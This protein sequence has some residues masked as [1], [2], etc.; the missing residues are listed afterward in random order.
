MIA[1]GVKSVFS[2]DQVF[3]IELFSVGHQSVF[4]ANS[5]FFPLMSEFINRNG[6]AGRR[7]VGALVSARGPA[8]VEM[9]IGEHTTQAADSDVLP[10]TR[11]AKRYV[12][13]PFRF[14][15]SPSVW[16]PG[17]EASS[18]GM[19]RRDERRPRARFRQRYI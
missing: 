15:N 12:E 2:V 13:T 8:S 4:S 6:R 3:S 19:S 11:R 18:S 9:T 5:S 1:T 10:S 17:G 14:L 16:A 7:S